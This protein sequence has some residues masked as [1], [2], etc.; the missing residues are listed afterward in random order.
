MG[1]LI[2]RVRG[3]ATG[4]SLAFFQQV[5][6]VVLQ[7][8]M[9]VPSNITLALRS[10]G[11]LEGTLKILYPQLDLIANARDL[12]RSVVGDIST[13]GVKR[14][15]SNQAVRTLPLLT[16]LPRRLNRITDD[17][18]NGRFTTHMRI[19]SHPDDRD[20]LTG[21]ANQVVV[22]VLAGFAVLGAILLLVT[23]GGPMLDRFRVY[24]I[25][26]YLLGFAGL[27]LAVRSVAMVFGRRT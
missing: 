9:S 21:L 1:V 10:L 20:F 8:G 23:S 17:L 6:K 2:T 27:V 15:L 26:G 7:H 24:D 22:A 11:S 5:L 3:G 18:Q 25:L 4:G 14:Q 12:S 16:Q 13:D 19:V